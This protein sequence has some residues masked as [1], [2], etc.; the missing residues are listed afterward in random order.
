MSNQLTNISPIDGRYQ[1]K[2]SELGDFF[3][4]MAL[5]KY[6]ILAEVKY[7]IA[8]G[9]EKK[10]K[11][12]KS[13]DDGVKKK[14]NG[15]WRNFDIKD[16]QRVKEI[17]KTTDHDVKS[18]EYFIKEKIKNLI[19]QPA[20]NKEFIHFALTSEDI[21][22]LA[23]ALQI[24]EAVEQVYLPAVKELLSELKNM[25][26]KN[27]G[28]GLLS[29]THGQPATPTTLGK[30]LAV[31]Y[32]RLKNQFEKLEKHKFYGKMNGASGCFA[33]H[34][35][36][37][38]EVDWVKFSKNFV[39]GLGLAF[40]PLTTQIE[41][42]DS[43][44]EALDNI[45]RI[46][47]IVI[48]FDQDMWLYISRG[49]FLQERKRGEVGSS[50]MPH[51]INPWYFENSEG[52]LSIANAYAQALADKLPVSRLQRDLRDSTLIRNQ[53]MVIAHSVFAYKKTLAGL[54]KLAVDKQ[55][56]KK[57][58]EDHPEVLS[59]AVQTILRKVGY[60]NPYEKLKEMTRGRRVG[61]EGIK[62]F[63]EGLDIDDG[64]K[65]KLLKLDAGGYVGLAEE[66]VERFV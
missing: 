10:V 35:I 62:K 12:V 64:E 1:N 38:P 11:E 53:G 13:F 44:V 17:E 59:E 27:K 21:N 63:I 9:D 41:S 23:Y 30:E 20:D 37:Y 4:E 49:L 19:R 34:N 26:K 54:K 46:N 50:T 16:A 51:K 57:E 7:L 15:L 47:N 55:A 24:K 6:R 61:I 32:F 60:P 3:S 48:D 36:A 25:A 43:L 18:V 52:N 28:V 45:R 56:I 65:K 2:V 14:L 33:A 31:F 29:M 58:L 22:N 8:L 5:M 42:H 66:L 40:N 39:E